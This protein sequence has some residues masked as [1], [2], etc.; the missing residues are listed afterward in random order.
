[1]IAR[2]I[3]RS[4]LLAVLT[5]SFL[6]GCV[7]LSRYDDL[8]A[9]NLLRRRGPGPG[10]GRKDALSRSA[11]P[12]AR[13]DALQAAIDQYLAKIDN[14]NKMN[15][16][17]QQKYDALQAQYAALKGGIPNPPVGVALPEA[18]DK[19]LL[20]LVNMYPDMLEYDRAH[21]MVKFKTDLLFAKG[22][23]DVSA[24]GKDALKKFADILG[25]V[26]GVRFNV[27]IAGHTDDIPIK[28]PD[29]LM[30]HP[31]NWYLSRAPVHQRAGDPGERQHGPQADRRAGLQH[32]PP[33]GPQRPRQRGQPAQPPRG[34]SDRPARPLPDGGEHVG[35]G[36]GPFRRLRR[37][38]EIGAAPRMS[39][40]A[41]AMRA[42]LGTQR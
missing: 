1:M 38:T 39:I 7:S 35:R 30:R 32:V 17:L 10:A 34:D 21:G 3:S 22:S 29:T 14:L 33:R 36:A 15:A 20:E 40:A 19:A 13:A 42:R 27:Y 2:W 6:Q 25:G 18:L 12:L 23:D 28:K 16:D 31:N 8:K 41:L 37:G 4:S 5:L 9:D 26:S 11:T 24:E